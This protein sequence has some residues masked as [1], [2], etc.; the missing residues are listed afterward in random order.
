[1]KRKAKT[2]CFRHRRAYTGKKCPGC[3]IADNQG[4]KPLTM[5]DWKRME[6]AQR[7]SDL[8]DAADAYF[9][10][11]DARLGLSGIA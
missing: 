4:I 5:R 1:M 11:R 8:K 10:E 3:R 9:R 7:I 6:A 2:V